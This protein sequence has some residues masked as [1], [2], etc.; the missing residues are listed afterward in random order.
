MALFKEREPVVPQVEE[1][2]EDADA[3]RIERKEVVTPTPSQFKAQVNDEAGKPLIQ[4]PQNQVQTITLPADPA[5][6]EQLGKGGAEESLTWFGVYWLRMFKKAINMG[7]NW[8][9][10][11]K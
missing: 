1:R 11:Q 3:L 2:P 4:T 9:V 8:L 6:L 5:A 10:G 7:W